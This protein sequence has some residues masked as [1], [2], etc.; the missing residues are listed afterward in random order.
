MPSLDFVCDAQGRPLMPMSAAYARTLLQQAKAHLRPHPA[1]T[2]VELTKVVAAPTL[3]P[4]VVSFTLHGTTANLEVVID[5]ART[6][7]TS[8]SI[9][10]ELPIYLRP[11]SSRRR[12]WQ[13]RKTRAERIVHAI[14]M[15]PL[16]YIARTLSSVVD[17]LQQFIPIS[18]WFLLPPQ[19][20]SVLPTLAHRRMRRLLKA[21]FVSFHEQHP[22][23]E[24]VISSTDGMTPLA[25]TFQKF[26]MHSIY[27]PPIA[28]ACIN[29]AR[30]PRNRFI[31]LPNIHRRG[32][33]PPMQ[34]YL[35]NVG[36]VC[37]VK[38]E[39]RTFTGIVSSVRSGDRMVVQ[40]PIVSHDEQVQWRFITISSQTPIHIWPSSKV[41][42]LPLRRTNRL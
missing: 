15:S 12:R 22:I 25:Q 24:I 16:R 32:S 34:V 3:R 1:F 11:L 8:F 33:L 7:P 14:A 27:Q 4:V 6:S 9:V 26:L 18:H 30:Q 36:K 35:Q 21:E 41:M 20:Q 2:I 40:V 39:G 42:L 38:S 31:Q 29:R 23:H 37:T 13:P 17:L 10:A 28:I 5:Q 19:T